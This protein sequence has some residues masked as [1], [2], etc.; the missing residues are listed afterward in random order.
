MNSLDF[1][2]VLPDSSMSSGDIAE[3]ESQ[4]ESSNSSSEEVNLAEFY[5]L[6]NPLHKSGRPRR[7]SRKEKAEKLEFQ[8]QQRHFDGLKE[9][10]RE[11][12]RGVSTTRPFKREEFV[13][14]YIGERINEEEGEIREKRYKTQGKGCFMFYFTVKGETL[15]IDAT[16][17][18]SSF[19]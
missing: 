11:I 12:G 2:E 6:R 15:I 13:C 10:E 17:E 9:I 4:A 14:T 5:V 19:G 7:L 8:V 3:P 16:C 18:K 1:N